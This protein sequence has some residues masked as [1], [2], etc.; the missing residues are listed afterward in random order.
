MGTNAAVNIANFTLYSFEYTWLIK[1][2]VLKAYHETDAIRYTR[3]YLDDIPTINNPNFI[4]YK[5]EIYHAKDAKGALMLELN[6][7][8][9]NLPLH[10]LDVHFYYHTTKK[11]LAYKLH[12]KFNDPKFEGL[13]FT[14]Y[15]HPNS[16]IDP[17]I[18]YNTFTGECNRLMTHNSFFN[19]FIDDI[20]LLIHYLLHKGYKAGKLK[21]KLSEFIHNHQPFFTSR[22]PKQAFD[23][24]WALVHQH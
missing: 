3:R 19:T 15:P 22:N 7:E 13:P 20:L 4:I 11:C 9:N 5:D 12:S 6:L 24:I 10:C 21:H 16:Y 18:L 2:L 1:K 17:K 14:R 8:S 23:T